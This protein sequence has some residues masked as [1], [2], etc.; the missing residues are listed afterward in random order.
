MIGSLY[1]RH[2][3][4][5]GNSH[6]LLFLLF[7]QMSSAWETKGSVCNAQRNF[8]ASNVLKKS[9]HFTRVN[10]V[11]ASICWQSM[12]LDYMKLSPIMRSVLMVTILFAA[13]D[14]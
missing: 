3:N 7:M 8:S 13:T 12:K 10:T 2:N 5:P 11:N 6:L 4:S 1:S 14:R 9:A